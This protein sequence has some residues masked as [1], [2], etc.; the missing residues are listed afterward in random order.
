VANKKRQQPV[1]PG[2]CPIDPNL[3]I[4]VCPPPT[5]I[6][7]IKVRKVFN[8]CMHTQVE[9]IEIEVPKIIGKLTTQTQEVQCS[10]VTARNVNCQ[11]LGNNV[12]RVSFDLEVCTRIP[13]DIGGSTELC[14][15]RQVAKTFRV[16]RANEANMDVQCHVFPECLFCFV[17][18]RGPIDCIFDN[19]IQKAYKDL[20]DNEIKQEYIKLY[21]RYAPL[22]SRIVNRDFSLK[23]YKLL[24]K[25]S[26]AIQCSIDDNFGHDMQIDK[27]NIEK[28]ASFL[29]ELQNEVKK[30]G[31]DYNSDGMAL[32]SF[33]NYCTEKLNTFEGENLVDLLKNFINIYKNKNLNA[34][35]PANDFT[36]PIGIKE[37]TCCVGILILIKVDS[38]VQ[39]LI[40]TYGYPA[41]PPECGEF[42]GE[43]PTDFTPAWP[44]YPP[45]TG[46]SGGTSGCKGCK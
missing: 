40:P 28:I 21:N 23:A 46:F 43:C 17:S 15:T 34:S 29:L 4:P 6:D 12:V 41:P 31:L 3:G 37:V 5:E 8:E 30:A 7:I 45:Q 32:I 38:E 16:D 39:L 11:A 42:L 25:Y 24:N 27:N 44:P 1:F 22:L 2:P 20:P 14:E 33:C 9:E 18:D 26:P 19:F 35:L 13:L 36:I 10:T